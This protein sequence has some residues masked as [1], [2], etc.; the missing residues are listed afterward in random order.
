MS[1]QVYQQD[2]IDKISR[3]MPHFSKV[4]EVGDRVMMGLEGDPAYPFGSERPLA[5]V[6]GVKNNGDDV[7][8]NLRM[9][10][11]AEQSV[12]SMSINPKEVWEFTDD[13]FQKVMAR[14]QRHAARAEAAL[15]GPI[16]E[17]ETLPD[18]RSVSE[19]QSQIDE[20]KA[21]LRAER[22]MTRNFHNVY[23]KTM[24]ELASD[25]MKL[26]RD[27]DTCQF[28]KVFD[29]EYTKMQNRAEDSLYRGTETHVESDDSLSDGATEY[30]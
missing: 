1:S 9:D 16:V 29:K 4:A 23:I 7:I 8:V 26:D 27:G 3:I 18:N 14:E 13:A 24:H 15:A 20:L 30:F 5:T 17:P 21:E 12:S 19:M 22:D 25:V 28:C 6:T 10:N 2:R 11:G